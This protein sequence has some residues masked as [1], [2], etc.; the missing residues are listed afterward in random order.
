MFNQLSAHACMHDCGKAA[1]VLNGDATPAMEQLTQAL[2]AQQLDK[3]ALQQ[4]RSQL[5]SKVR[6][7]Q[8]SLWCAT[9]A[10]ATVFH[11]LSAHAC[12]AA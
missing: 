9:W 1:A 11:Q 4:W 7:L 6:H 12:N 10:A 8:Q 3:A 2:S 5:A